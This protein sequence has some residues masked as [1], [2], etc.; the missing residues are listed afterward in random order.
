VLVGAHVRGGGPLAEVV[1]R[2]R[3]LGAEAIQIFTQSPRMW[4]PSRHSPDAIAAFRDA[5]DAQ[6]QV[7]QVFCHATYLVNLA[8]ADGELLERSRSCLVDNLSVATAMGADGLVL[9]VGSHRGAGMDERLDQVVAVLGSVLDAVASGPD[10]PCPILL[11]NAAGAGGTVGRDVEELGRIL[12]RLDAGDQVGMC[13]DTQ[14]LWASGVDFSTP[15]G[16]VAV[17]DA[18]DAAVGLGRLR[19]L[20]LN[21]SAVPFGANRDRHA[22]LGAGTIGTDGLATL[23]G[24][25][26]LGGLA[27]IL[28]VPGAGDGPTAEQVAL[29]KTVVADGQVR[30]AAGWPAG[31]PST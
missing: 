29:A 26:S 19:C 3:E 13:L 24:H 21:D 8:T 16:A 10:G 5:L 2:G 27:A 7:Q 31:P 4:R 25:P 18:I 23:V 12:D 30:W 14:H 6:D 11:E 17:L 22:N 15:E 28:E 1:G 9:H 20:H